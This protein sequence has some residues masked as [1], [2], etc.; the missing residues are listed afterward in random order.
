[1]GDKYNIDDFLNNIVQPQTLKEAFDKKLDELGLKPT[2]V[3]D[4]L[5]LHYRALNKILDG[6]QKLVDPTALIKIANFVQLPKEQVFKLYL[7]AVE[8]HYPVQT[9]SPQKIKFIKENF[10]LAVLKKAGFIDSITDFDH[11]EKRL[12]SRLGLRSLFEYKKP[13]ID[14]AFS[15]GIFKPQNNLTRSFWIKAAMT[16]FEEIDNPHEYSREELI[17]II[18]RIRWY[19]MNVEHGL[20]EVIKALYGV[21]VT[22]IYQPALLTLQLRG[23]TFS[24]NDKPCIVL[25]NYVGFY[26]TLWFALMHELFHVVF[27]WDEISNHKY[28]LTDDAN[29]QLSVRERENEADTFAREYLFSKDKLDTIRPF[30]NDFSFVKEYAEENHVHHSIPFTFYAFEFGKKDRRA[31]P[32]ARMYDADVKSAVKNIDLPWNTEKK[33]EEIFENRKSAIYI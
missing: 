33:V 6:T 24:V 23:A 7:D 22:V 14:I 21:G 5:G 1:M 26:A 25:T 28:H 20:S 8:K 31:W 27:D 29:E 30:I 16:C 9:I 11:I 15:S 32:R 4:I 18:P 10:D 13:T 17:K 2:A 19:T 12:L 3:L